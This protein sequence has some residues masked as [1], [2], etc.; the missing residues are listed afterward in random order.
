V[1]FD[2]RVSLRHV[3]AALAGELSHEAAARG[4]EDEPQRAFGSLVREL[5]DRGRVVGAHEPAH[6]D[7]GFYREL[8]VLRISGWSRVSSAIATAAERDERA[9][10]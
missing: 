6:A 4:A 5:V 10:L 7:H 9:R 3:V 8:A 2:P 1:L